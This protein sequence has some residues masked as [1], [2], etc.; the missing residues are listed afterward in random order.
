[1]TK[2][3]LTDLSIKNNVRL[4]GDQFSVDVLGK[5]NNNQLENLLVNIVT[6]SSLYKLEP[7]RK[8]NIKTIK[9][10]EEWERKSY[11]KTLKKKMM[12]E[13]NKKKQIYNNKYN[14]K[15]EKKMSDESQ[16]EMSYDDDSLN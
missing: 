13:E 9:N 4:V 8:D 12:I 15:E 3:G 11:E 14:E 2:E 10:K 16:S 5:K 1:M 7:N 6:N